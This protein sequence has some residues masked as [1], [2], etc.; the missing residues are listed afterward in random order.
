MSSPPSHPEEKPD[1]KAHVQEVCAVFVFLPD[2]REIP[3]KG[4]AVGGKYRTRIFLSSWLVIKSRLPEETSEVCLR[5]VCLKEV[6]KSFIPQSVSHG[7][8]SPTSLNSNS[9]KFQ[10]TL[11]RVMSSAKP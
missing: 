7:S 6:I 8:D 4:N 11:I 2:P 5:I 10:V 1:T 3:G 9:P